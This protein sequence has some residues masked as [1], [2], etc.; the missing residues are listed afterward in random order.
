MDTIYPQTI[1][2]PDYT[3]TTKATLLSSNIPASTEAEWDPVPTYN[4]NDIVKRLV[5][6]GDWAGLWLLY[7]AKGTTTGDIPELDDKTNWVSLGATE[8]YEMFDTYVMTDTVSSTGDI[9]IDLHCRK[10]SAFAFMNVQASAI[11]IEMW[12]GSELADKIEA[13]RVTNASWDEGGTKKIIPLKGS[14]NGYFQYFW[15]NFK[16]VRDVS[17]FDIPLRYN[18]VIQVTFKKYSGLDC[19]VGQVLPGRKYY[20]GSSQFPANPGFDDY[21]IIS[22]NENTGAVYLRKGNYK[23]K[24]DLEIIVKGGAQSV[25][26]AISLITQLR[27][28][29][30]IWEGNQNG[31]EYDGLLVYGYFKKIKAVIKRDNFT[32]IIFEIRGM[33]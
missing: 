21:S 29:P 5:Q 6:S 16:R 27:G 2:S 22:E 19:S 33:L 9:V 15:E 32:R 10:I 14:S 18:S 1:I 30:T 4:A 17:T 7:K 28:T 26:R 12:E 8:R 23:K 3:D 20:L 11:E 13:N 24:L 25:N 31:T